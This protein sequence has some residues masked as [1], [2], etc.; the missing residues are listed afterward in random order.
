M[1]LV[2]VMSHARLAIFAEIAMGIVLALFA[3]VLVY[4]FLRANR[5]VFERASRLPLEDDAPAAHLN[6][7]EKR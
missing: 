1:S 5:P 6:P 7:G 4:T 2:D 3:G